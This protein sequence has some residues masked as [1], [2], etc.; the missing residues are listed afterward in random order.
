[1][2]KLPFILTIFCILA[3]FASSVNS[4]VNTFIAYCS[5]TRILFCHDSISPKTNKGKNLVTLSF[6]EKLPLN[7]GQLRFEE[8]SKEFYFSILGKKVIFKFIPLKNP[9]DLWSKPWVCKYDSSKNYYNCGIDLLPGQI[10]I[11]DT[12]GVKWP[13]LAPIAQQYC[14]IYPN[15]P[16]C[17]TKNIFTQVAGGYKACGYCSEEFEFIGP[18]TK[19]GKDPLKVTISKYNLIICNKDIMIPSLSRNLDPL[20]PKF[21]P[22]QGKELFDKKYDLSKAIPLP[23]NAKAAKCTP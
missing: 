14:K 20:S 4:Q 13:T 2:K 11:T 23:P 17:T 22:S 9:S 10:V 1:M 5:G 7:S 12:N 8:S 3:S 18:S 21:L 6:T 16:G 19:L 15:S